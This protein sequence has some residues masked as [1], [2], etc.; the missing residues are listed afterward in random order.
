MDENNWR[1]DGG[2]TEDGGQI[3]GKDG[4]IAELSLIHI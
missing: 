3:D 1:K 4:Q 2:K